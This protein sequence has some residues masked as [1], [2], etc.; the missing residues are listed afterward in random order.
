MK[1][2]VTQTDFSDERRQ[3]YQMRIAQ[4]F[5]FTPDPGN[6]TVGEVELNSLDD[7]MKFLNIVDSPIIIEGN[8]IEINNDFRE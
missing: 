8:T 3:W 5:A 7:I 4:H 6:W 2:E 1:F